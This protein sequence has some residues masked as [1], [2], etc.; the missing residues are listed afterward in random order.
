MLY[1]FVFL[2]HGNNFGQANSG[3][4][5]SSGAQNQGEPNSWAPNGVSAFAS[6]SAKSKF[7]LE[8]YFQAYM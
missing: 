4:W 6:S 5:S 2:E 8:I 3:S 1:N 7:P